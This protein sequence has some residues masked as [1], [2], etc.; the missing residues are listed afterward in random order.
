GRQVDQVAVRERKRG[1][2]R[3]M[4]LRLEARE[5]VAEYLRESKRLGLKVGIASSSDRSWVTDHLS[6]LKLLEYF[7]CLTTFE[8]T[9]THKPEPGPYLKALERLGVT[10]SEAMALEDSAHGIAAA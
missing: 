10:A 6:R 5:G 1:I 4:N 3:E 9:T 8:D 7:A 2:C